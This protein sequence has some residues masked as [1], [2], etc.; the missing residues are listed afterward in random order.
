MTSRET[1]LNL[2]GINFS[3]FAAARI[4]AKLPHQEPQIL[5]SVPRV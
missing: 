5:L 2:R 4:L 1:V 3:P